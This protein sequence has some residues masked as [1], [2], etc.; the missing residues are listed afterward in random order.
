MLLHGEPENKVPTIDFAAD[1]NLPNGD[2]SSSVEDLE[3]GELSN[4]SKP[5]RNASGDILVPCDVGDSMTISYSS[6][7][8]VIEL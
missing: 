3:A 7:I 1:N 2:S 6:F 4:D 8:S 5:G